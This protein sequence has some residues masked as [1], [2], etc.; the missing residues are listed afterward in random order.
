MI[1]A[2]FFTINLNIS[3]APKIRAKNKRMISNDSM[4]SSSVVVYLV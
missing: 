4:M 1:P 2:M 3:H